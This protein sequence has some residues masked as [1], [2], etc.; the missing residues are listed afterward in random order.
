MDPDAFSRLL[1]SALASGQLA[2]ALQSALQNHSSSNRKY[3]P[4][5]IINFA[6]HESYHIR[7]N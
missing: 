7:L 6:K 1:T 4:F 2:N 3:K 5:S